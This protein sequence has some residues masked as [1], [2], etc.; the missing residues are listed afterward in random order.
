MNNVSGIQPC[1]SFRAVSTQASLIS[2]LV[3]AAWFLL[4]D[5]TTVPCYMWPISSMSPLYTSLQD[6]S[7]LPQPYWACKGWVILGPKLLEGTL[8]ERTSALNLTSRRLKTLLLSKKLWLSHLVVGQSA[9]DWS[10]RWVQKAWQ[11]SLHWFPPW[12][13]TGTWGMLV[14]A[15]PGA[16]RSDQTT[17]TKGFFNSAALLIFPPDCTI[18][19]PSAPGMCCAWELVMLYI[20]TMTGR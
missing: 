14:S 17:S 3:T 2:S 11:I 18:A 13:W 4:I 10:C 15:G 7:A 8:G 5:F 12:Y 9:G 19:I 1:S 16:D 6:T 20:F